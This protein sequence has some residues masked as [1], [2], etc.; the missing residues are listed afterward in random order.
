MTVL[1]EIGTTFRR[2]FREALENDSRVFIGT[3]MT[4]WRCL[5]TSGDKG[6]R[7]LPRN[8]EKI[9]NILETICN[10]VNVSFSNKT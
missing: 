10:R 7:V 6:M 2:F 9:Y 1:R 4:N 5:I 3:L 8:R